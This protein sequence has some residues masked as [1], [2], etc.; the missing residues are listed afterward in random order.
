VD[1]IV[2]YDYL[3]KMPKKS[4]NNNDNNEKANENV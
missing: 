1:I 3:K 4:K 2:E